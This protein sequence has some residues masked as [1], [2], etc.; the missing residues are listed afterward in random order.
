MVLLAKSP[1][2]T[3]YDLSSVKTII[4]GA[5]PLSE[6][7]SKE[8]QKKLNLE[9]IIQGTQFHTA[10][11]FRDNRLLF[12]KGFGMGVNTMFCGTLHIQCLS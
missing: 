7:L 1:L 3:Q 5:A 11:D 6:V 9:D 2:T 10:D 4:T 12:L 8:V